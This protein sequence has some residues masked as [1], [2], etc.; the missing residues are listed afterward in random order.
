MKLLGMNRRRLQANWMLSG[1]SN[2]NRS[3]YVFDDLV[4]ADILRGG[5]IIATLVQTASGV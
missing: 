4:I 1:P 2:M 5:H 3:Q